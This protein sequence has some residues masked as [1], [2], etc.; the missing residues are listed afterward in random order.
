MKLH[1]IVS[2]VALVAALTFSGSAFAQHM[3]DG[4][5]VPDDQIAAFKDKC[6]A[7]QAASNT[8]LA[9]SNQEDLSGEDEMSTGSVVQSDDPA[10]KEYWTAAM[11]SITL[12]ECEE[13]NFFLD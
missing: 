11:A 4:V 10:S 13:N 6:T 7:V 3:I 2:S 5:A 12:E 8:S 1:A 9:T